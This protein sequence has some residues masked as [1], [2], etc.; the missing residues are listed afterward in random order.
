[1][2]SRCSEADA[3][4]VLAPQDA[5]DVARR[6]ALVIDAHDGLCRRP[7]GLVDHPGP[8]AIG[9]IAQEPW[10][11]G[12]TL[13]SGLGDVRVR[14]RLPDKQTRELADRTTDRTLRAEALLRVR[15]AWVRRAAW[16]L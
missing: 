5:Q 10:L 7:S 1:M 8:L 2:S 9:R 16:E 6:I 12:L 14:A 11:A 13:P 15:S 4:Y 3:G